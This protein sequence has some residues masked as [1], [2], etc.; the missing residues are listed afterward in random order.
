MIF[1]AFITDELI[2]LPPKSSIYSPAFTPETDELDDVTTF[3]WNPSVYPGI[4]AITDEPNPDVVAPPVKP[5][6]VADDLAV[7]GVA[8]ADVE[9]TC[10]CC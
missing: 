9:N 2:H 5:P 4:S 3:F 8:V 1:T 7:A 10:N 6:T